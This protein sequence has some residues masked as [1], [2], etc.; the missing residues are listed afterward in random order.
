[1]RILVTGG[2]GFIGSKI[3]EMLCKD[4]HV[5]VVDN[6]DTYGIMTTE[7]L[8]KLYEWRTRNWDLKRVQTITGDILDR[9]VCLKAFSHNPDIV[10]HFGV[11]LFC[12]CNSRTTGRDA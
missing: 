4:H 7:E 2:Y 12:L 6:E 1:M 3:V 11:V 5:I 8:K 9:L 10:I